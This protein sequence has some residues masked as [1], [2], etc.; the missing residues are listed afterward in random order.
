MS[1]NLIANDFPIR[2]N[3]NS[4]AKCVIE[5]MEICGNHKVNTWL[6]YGALLGII[7]NKELLHW[8]ND[9]ELGCWHDNRNKQKFRDITD[10]Y[11]QFHIEKKEFKLV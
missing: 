11:F 4:L 2:S 3:V 9:A 5:V 10:Q 8:N 1:N 7:R 6:C